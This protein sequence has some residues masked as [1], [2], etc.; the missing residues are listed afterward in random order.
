MQSTNM[1]LTT[2]KL[3]KFFTVVLLFYRF[4]IKL[5]S[6]NT[7]TEQIKIANEKKYFFNNINSDN[8][9]IV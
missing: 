9:K 7:C 1:T 3:D 5:S 4:V 6:S 8:K 2:V